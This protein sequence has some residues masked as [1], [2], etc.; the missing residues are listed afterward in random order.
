MTVC[1]S[2]LTQLPPQPRSASA[3]APLTLAGT[4][5]GIAV[6]AGLI[7]LGLTAAHPRLAG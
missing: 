3:P 5:A 4:V 7:G 6:T 1:S 2:P